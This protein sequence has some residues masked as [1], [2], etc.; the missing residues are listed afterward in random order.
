ML[1]KESISSAKI[2][3]CPLSTRRKLNLIALGGCGLNPVLDIRS[4]DVS[5]NKRE[6]PTVCT[7]PLNSRCTSISWGKFGSD[8]ENELGLI[9]TG[10]EDGSVNL[11]KPILNT[12][13]NK[14]CSNLSLEIVCNNSNI[15]NS[16]INC[17]EFNKVETNLLASGGS[18][19][20]IFVIDLKD[21]VTGNLNHFEPGKENKHGDSDLTSVKWNPKVS[22]ILASSSGNGTTAIWD[23]KLKKSAISFRDPAQRSRPSTLAWVPNQ[24]TQIIVG[25][26][27][28]R[29]PSLQ[30]WDLRNVSYP[31][32]ETV[33]AHQ[34]GIMSVDFSQVDS[35]LL[36]S[37][38]KDGKI[39]CWTLLNNQQPEIFTELVSQ[40]W[41]VQN[42][43][44]PIIPG[45]FATASHNDKIG[46]FSLSSHSN[47]T[48]YIPSWYHKPS[49]VNFT[50]SGK[51]VS[52]SRK[53]SGMNPKFKLYKVPSNPEITVH[54]D[55]FDELLNKG[56]YVS[57]CKKKSQESDNSNEKLAWNL[58][59]NM[60]SVDSSERRLYIASLLG[61]DFN[62]SNL[63]A[64]QL[65]GRNTGV[66]IQEELLKNEMNNQLNDTGINNNINE[67]N[68]NIDFKGTSN[69]GVNNQELG[70]Y[71]LLSGIGS[72]NSPN[73]V[74]NQVNSLL[75]LDPEKFFQQLGESN[76]NGNE[77][78][79]G[80]NNNIESVQGVSGINGS[81][82]INYGSAFNASC[83]DN[84]MDKSAL[85]DN[86]PNYNVNDNNEMFDFPRSNLSV[87]GSTSGSRL[88]HSVKQREWCKKEEDVI[89]NLVITG[90]IDSAIDVCVE[91]GFFSEAFIMA[92]RLGG[93]HLDYVQKQYQRKHDC[94]YTQK[95]IGYVILDDLENFVKNSNLDRWNETLAIISIYTQPITSYNSNVIQ[96][97]SKY[98]MESLS[99]LLGKRLEEE[100]F[101]VRS[102]LICYL[103]ARN[104]R[105][106]IEIWGKMT[107]CQTSLILGLQDFVEKVAVL[108]AATRFNGNDENITKQVIQYAEILANS[109]RIVAAMKF[110]SSLASNDHS[111]NSLILRDRIYNAAPELMNSLGFAK[112]NFPFTIV[113]LYPDVNSNNMSN[114]QHNM[115]NPYQMITGNTGMPVN[116]GANTGMAATGTGLRLGVNAGVGQMPPSSISS[117]PPP[118]P[119]HAHNQPNPQTI[120]PGNSSSGVGILSNSNNHLRPVVPGGGGLQ[121]PILPPPPPLPPQQLPVNSGVNTGSLIGGGIPNIN[122]N[123]GSFVNQNNTM[124][125]SGLRGSM[126][127]PPPSQSSSHSSLIQSS[128]IRPSSSI[129]STG[130]INNPLPPPPQNNILTRP[131]SPIVYNQGNNLVGQTNTGSFGGLGSALN[132]QKGFGSNSNNFNPTFQTPNAS[133]IPPIPINTS[134][135]QNMSGIPSNPQIGIGN[136]NNN[137][138]S[139]NHM[140]ASQLSIASTGGNNNS[141]VAAGIIGGG[142]VDS[143][144]SNPPS[145]PLPVGRPSITTAPH[146]GAK[147]PIPGMPVPWPL[148]TA[149]QQLSSTTS[150]TANANRQIQEA[151]KKS[152]NQNLGQA[153]APQLMDMVTNVINTSLNNMFSNEPRKKMDA[154]KKFDE[155][156]E[157]LRSGNISDSVSSKLVNLCKS[158]QTGDFSTANKIHIDL[159]S[160][161]WENNKNWLMALKRIIPK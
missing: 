105:S 48:T 53:D 103:C 147:P 143:S 45:I 118:T 91:R 135:S 70:G 133:S 138:S 146:S 4:L 149:T 154:Q 98:T 10:L 141:N 49:G 86:K 142:V 16:S 114:Y 79:S 44:S 1:L 30:L 128:Q 65:L 131:N 56:D 29:N 102:A 92:T 3:W 18:D 115:S 73:N 136:N 9:C 87:T 137:L 121:Q 33:S 139:F 11:F 22:H 157:K 126:P 36:L 125:S 148:P 31:F 40:Q 34:K 54:A 77:D 20:K 23:L 158:I 153:L 129:V 21:G 71:S 5:D 64:N 112:P 134:N 58:V 150:T 130:M 156:F 25:Y 113:E 152:S 24:P 96:F 6:L 51:L 7:T 108:Q 144:S 85:F 37:S 90:N 60:F 61:Y 72:Q 117:F 38:G 160:T 50:F 14:V 99:E 28:D 62:E 13:D 101:D 151:S 124:F 39:I 94:Y 46:I 78:G 81:G 161:E 107:S 42:L 47:T 132:N 159:S 63:Q 19:G 68:R 75:S 82:N 27:D 32:K 122:S 8:C 100:K 111:I 57:Y 123:S 69:R 104:F 76:S 41:N 97:Q 2:S 12:Y 93:T 55:I 17:L 74:S 43:W 155:L 120:I 95:M 84:Q 106:S 127:P 67:S 145:A 110:L 35:N 80:D 88:N 59:E 119:P 66:L 52:F 83:N 89:N 26:D 15:H 140:S 109:G 116:V